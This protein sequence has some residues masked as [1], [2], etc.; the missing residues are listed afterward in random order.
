MGKPRFLALMLCLLACDAGSADTDPGGA[1][2]GVTVP[3]SRRAD[4]GEAPAGPSEEAT[5]VQMP[6]Q[7]APAAASTVPD[8]KVV[9]A[10]VGNPSPADGAP[11]APIGADAAPAPGPDA[12][13]ACSGAACPCPNDQE[14][15]GAGT[16][17]PRAMYGVIGSAEFDG[18]TSEG[19]AGFAGTP[20]GFWVAALVHLPAQPTHS[21]AIAG[22]GNFP[23]GWVLVSHQGQ[24]QL[25]LGVL[26]G[27]VSQSSAS[28]I[29]PAKP[30][31][32]GKTHLVVGVFDGTSVRIYLDGDLVGAP[33]PAVFA[34]YEVP[35]MV[36]GRPDNQFYANRDYIIA[37]FMAGRA[38]PTLMEVVALFER[39]KAE[40]KL[41]PIPA[42]T[43]RLWSFDAAGDAPERVV[44]SITGGDPLL[45]KGSLRRERFVPN[46]AW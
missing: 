18:Y 28:P 27:T 29:C 2:S 41:E 33:Q 8:A 25:Q 13:P 42:K 9:D 20:Q 22:R 15:D 10:Q 21:T 35:F 31:D 3:P 45:R 11:L 14:R 26:N 12:S 46:F 1:W 4:A 7:D 24:F 16:C 36:S 37:G 6:V 23:G 44:D 30:E 34:P 40:R 43:E 5:G 38:A 17:M 32:V 19:V 39:V